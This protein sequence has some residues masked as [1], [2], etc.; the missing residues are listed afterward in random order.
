MCVE[1]E[2]EEEGVM[3]IL[4]YEC[5]YMQMLTRFRLE[6]KLIMSRETR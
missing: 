2:E 3:W 5:E 4:I 6:L 1:E